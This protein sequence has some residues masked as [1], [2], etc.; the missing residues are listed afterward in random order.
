MLTQFVIDVSR[1]YFYFIENLSRVQRRTLQL[2]IF[3]SR[4]SE[5]IR[6]HHRAPDAER[7]NRIPSQERH[8]VVPLGLERECASG[9]RW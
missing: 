6:M 2:V 5:M 3:E 9:K 7:R 1:T 8:E 4:N